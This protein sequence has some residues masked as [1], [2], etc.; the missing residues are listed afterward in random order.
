MGGK[1]GEDYYKQVG[2]AWVW[3]KVH[4]RVA[5]RGKSMLKE[6]LGYPIGS[7]GEV[8]D[9]LAQ[10][11]REQGSEVHLSASVNRVVIDDGVATGFHLCCARFGQ[12]CSQRPSQAAS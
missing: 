2:M 10:R 5:S 4:T 1:C 9:V 12:Q 6:K 8:F 7:F 3:G 11:I